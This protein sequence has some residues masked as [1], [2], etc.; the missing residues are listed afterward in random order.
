M[1]LSIIVPAYNE[2]ENIVNTIEAVYN[3]VKKIRDIDYEVLIVNDGSSDN[4]LMMAQQT[5]KGEKNGR[6]ISHSFNK[7]LGEAIKTGFANFT[8]DYVVV[9][10]ADLSYGPEYIVIL[11]REIIKCR[12]VDIITTSPYMSGGR[13]RNIPFFRLMLS[14]LGNRVI[15][16][17]MN[18]PLHTVTSM[19]RIYK[20]RV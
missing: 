10:D 7:G 11:L 15:A 13:T 2:E 3:A 8:G 4:T 9:M 1:K 6:V 16:Y 20:K 14:K 17:A 19:V 12:D 18:C 5:L